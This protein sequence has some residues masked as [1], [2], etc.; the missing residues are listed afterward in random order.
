MRNDFMTFIQRSFYE[1]NPQANFIS[2]QYIELA[3]ATLEK[4]RTAKTTRLILNLLPYAEVARRERCLP[5]LVAGA[6]SLEANHLRELRPGSGRYASRKGA[7]NKTA[8]R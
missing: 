2:G 4:C 6:R 7:F 1:L 5:S 3:A 8:R